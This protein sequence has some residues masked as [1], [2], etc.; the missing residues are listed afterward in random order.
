MA[1]V[2]FQV[3]VLGERGDVC[4]PRASARSLRLSQNV[5]RGDNGILN[6][7]PGY[8][9]L[10]VDS[11][12]GGRIMGVGHFKTVSSLDRQIAA[13]RTSVWQFDGTTW[14]NIT[15][16]PLT[17]TDYDHVR[18]TTFYELGVYKTIITNSVNTPK[19]W[20]GSTPTYIELGGSPGVAID[21]VVCAN[22]ALLLQHPN[23]VRV[24]EFNNAQIYPALVGFIIDLIDSGDFMVGMETL[25]RTAVAVL[26]EESQWVLRSQSGPFPFKP[27]RISEEVGPM[28]AAA[29]VNVGS[30]V[31]YLGDDYNVYKFDGVSCTAV[32]WAMK[33]WV[34]S[35]IN[36][37]N[38]SMAHGEYFDL[39]GK[40]FWFF[41]AGSST[42]PNYGIHLDPRLARWGGFIMATGSLR[43]AGGS[44]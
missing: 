1:D 12:P 30:A 22:R 15:G 13:N 25:T 40:I 17:G 10:P 26:G 37:G 18:F 33:N 7:R 42:A 5:F 14:V 31:Y 16:T 36:V 4:D 24:S 43:R 28:S 35:N 19:I 21:S 3:P 39:I 20:D 9:K 32:G 41:P 6:I 2:Q 38:K 44:R 8:K 29:I 34:K 23:R 27:E 11:S